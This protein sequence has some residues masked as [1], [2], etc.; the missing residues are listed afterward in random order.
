[1]ATYQRLAPQA[2]FKRRIAEMLLRYSIYPFAVLRALATSSNISGQT[3][4]AEYCRK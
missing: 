2:V 4:M 1:M 3:M